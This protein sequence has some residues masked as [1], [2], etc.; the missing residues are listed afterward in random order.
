M[1]IYL[2]Y[3]LLNRSQLPPL[4]IHVGMLLTIMPATKRLV[5]VAL[6]VDVKGDVTSNPKQGYRWPQN[7][8]MCVC[9]PKKFKKYILVYLHLL[10]IYLE[11]G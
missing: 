2:L 5:G 8:D 7:P 1:F 4:L 11:T 10:V 6:V 3:G 9:P